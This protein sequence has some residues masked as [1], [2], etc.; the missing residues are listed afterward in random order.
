VNCARRRIIP[1]VGNQVRTRSPALRAVGSLAQFQ[2]IV[3]GSRLVFTYRMTVGESPMSAS[4][5]TVEFSPAGTGTH[6]VFTEQGAFFD[7]I[8]SAKGRE[9]GSRALLDKLAAFL[10]G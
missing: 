8:D 9:E 3:P 7:G 6:L 5:T 1:A 2:D 10:P 4:L